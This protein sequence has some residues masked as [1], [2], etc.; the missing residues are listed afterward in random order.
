VVPGN[1]SLGSGCVILNQVSGSGPGG[2]LICGSTGSW[3]TTLVEV[4][5]IFLNNRVVIFLNCCFFQQM[6][7]IVLLLVIHNCHDPDRPWNVCC[8]CLWSS[9]ET[10]SRSGSSPPSSTHSTP[11]SDSQL[12]TTGEYFYETVQYQYR[13]IL[14]G[15]VDRLIIALSVDQRGTYGP[16]WLLKVR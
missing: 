12:F 10:S 3:S 11:G 2:L 16:C 8:S 14:C 1:I 15:V 5:C 7:T 13:F 6:S 4:T 9:E